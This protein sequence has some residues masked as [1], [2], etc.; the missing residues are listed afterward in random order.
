MAAACVWSVWSVYSGSSR[1]CVAPYDRN[2]FTPAAAATL[3]SAEREKERERE[4]ERERERERERDIT[5]ESS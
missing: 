5:S 1:M 2:A 4:G 3:M